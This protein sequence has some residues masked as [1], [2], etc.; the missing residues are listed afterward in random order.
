MNEIALLLESNQKGVSLKVLIQENMMGIAELPNQVL[1]L[2]SCLAWHWASKLAEMKECWSLFLSVNCFSQSMCY[3]SGPHL[4]WR[5]LVTVTWKHT[6]FWAN[7]LV[8]WHGYSLISACNW[9]LS[10]WTGQ[11]DHAETESLNFP[12]RNRKTISL[13]FSQL[14]SHLCTQHKCLKWEQRQDIEDAHSCLLGKTPQR[15]L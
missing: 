8:A 15:N 7:S 9:F 11:P 4:E 2:Y 10:N 14:W 1:S 6:I 3:V 5:W 13:P 12:P